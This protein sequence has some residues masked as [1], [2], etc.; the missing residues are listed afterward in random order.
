MQKQ[1]AINWLHLASGS[2]DTLIIG[3]LNVHGTFWTNEIVSC[4]YIVIT[5]MDG[6]SYVKP[7][8]IGRDEALNPIMLMCHLTKKKKKKT[9]RVIWCDSSEGQL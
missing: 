8:L 1:R 3:C 9:F 5:G 7:L 4:R 6:G 2:G